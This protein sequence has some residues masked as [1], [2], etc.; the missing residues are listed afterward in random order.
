[1]IGPTQ[2]ISGE[3]IESKAVNRIQSFRRLLPDSLDSRFRS[4]PDLGNQ[5]AAALD[6][7]G[8]RF[9]YPE[10]RTPGLKKATETI[11]V[12]PRRSVAAFGGTFH[13]LVGPVG[14]YGGVFH[15]KLALAASILMRFASTPEFTDVSRNL[16]H[17]MD[18]IPIARALDPRHERTEFTDAQRTL[19]EGILTLYQSLSFLCSNRLS[20]LSGDE[21]VRRLITSPEAGKNGFT[22]IFSRMAPGGFI[23]PVIQ[24][25]EYFPNP[26]VI[27]EQGNL[28]PNPALKHLLLTRRKKANAQINEGSGAS[29]ATGATGLGCPA[30][31]CGPDGNNTSSVQIIA[32][33]FYEIFRAL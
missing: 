9:G 8:S 17:F 18:G 10:S 30:A 7:H 22:A 25:G 14:E 24:S 12:F 2:N 6:F 5:I 29:F 16:D 15:R 23:G 28:V 33:M 26:L 20:D 3:L 27:S 11:M 1:M 13:L 32:D 21:L 31:L 4:D 19:Q